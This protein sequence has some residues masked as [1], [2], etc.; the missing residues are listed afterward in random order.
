MS[1]DRRP[2]LLLVDR[3]RGR[4]WRQP[5]NPNRVRSESSSSCWGSR[6]SSVSSADSSFRFCFEPLSFREGVALLF[7]WGMLAFFSLTRLMLGKNAIERCA[8][9]LVG[10]RDLFSG[11]LPAFPHAH[12]G[13]ALLGVCFRRC[14]SEAAPCA[15]GLQASFCPFADDA[16]LQLSHDSTELKNRDAYG[17]SC[18]DGVI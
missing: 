16:F 12:D 8:A 17:R 2:S 13:V 4:R 1:E 9:D 14:A 7:G 6:R 11:V 15:G 5:P 10:F 18:V 3:G